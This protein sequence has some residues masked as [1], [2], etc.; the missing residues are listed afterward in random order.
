MPDMND[1]YSPAVLSAVSRQLFVAGPLLKR[2]LQHWRPYI[3]PFGEILRHV[4]RDAQVLDIGCGGGLLLGLLARLRG[5]SGVGFDM[6]PDAIEVA[7][8]MAS[9]QPDFAGKLQFHVLRAQEDWP[10]TNAGVVTIVDVMHHV[11][12]DAIASVLTKTFSHVP[13]GGRLIYKDM[14]SRPLWRATHNRLHDLLVARQWI[15]YVDSNQ[16]VR[17]AE[18]AGLQCIH[19]TTINCGPYGHELRVFDRPA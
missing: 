4:P 7:R 8:Q 1:D 14:A 11:P 9:R 15:H 5:V 19:A 3:C 17:L 13:P 18:Q 12:P 10:T 2:K 16:V 6:S